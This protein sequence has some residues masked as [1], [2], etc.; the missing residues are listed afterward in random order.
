M[1]KLLSIVLVVASVMLLLCSCAV[2]HK[3]GD[4]V[5]SGNYTY[6]ILEDN[7]AKIIKY[8]S[9]EEMLE[10]EIPAALDDLTVTV[11]GKGA[12]SDCQTIGAVTF[13]ETITIVEESSFNN[14]SIKKA[15]MHR[16]SGL[17]EIGE[18]AFA[19][20]HSLV[21]IDMPRSLETIGER[22]FYYCEKLKVANFRG[23]TA[24]IDVFA[25]DAS[26]NVKIYA[27]SDLVNVISF[28][29]TNKIE[30]SVSE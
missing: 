13:P 12:F 14:S 7:T 25:F 8:T 27:D 16:S 6:E 10:L 9:S 28:A 15:L 26:P 24:N 11:I 1:K 23:D 3:A 4:E 21:Q 19:E 18:N 30:L 20:C 5:V 29:K 17:T 2:G 22:A